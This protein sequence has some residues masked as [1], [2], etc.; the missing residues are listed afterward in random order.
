MALVRPRFGTLI[1]VILV[2][3]VTL[4]PTAQAQVSQAAQSPGHHADM[5]AH[6]QTMMKE[7][8]A[9]QQKIDDLTARMNSASGQAKTDL[10]AALLDELLAQ[11]KAMHARMAS[12]HGNMMHNEAAPADAPPVD[13]SQ[14]N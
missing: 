7:M 1:A 14:H 2:L 12:M 5:K 11:R 10:M 6:C 3:G 4:I 8:A 9:G 13:H